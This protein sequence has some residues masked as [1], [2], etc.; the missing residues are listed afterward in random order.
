M[1][2]RMSEAN[3]VFGVR[4]SNVVAASLL[5]DFAVGT[6]VN[7]DNSHLLGGG[8]PGAGTS[9]QPPKPSPECQRLQKAIADIEAKVA[10]NRQNETDGVQG[11][12][13]LES[14]R[15]QLACR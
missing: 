15:S 11:I 4:L 9:P 8:N 6:I 10:A 5:N 7:D 3:E 2:D 12:L 14:K 13:Q 1:G